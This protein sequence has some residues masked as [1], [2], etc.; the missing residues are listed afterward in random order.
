MQIV[1]YYNSTT[2][3]LK[4][5]LSTQPFSLRFFITEKQRGRQLDTKVCSSESVRLFLLCS[6]HISVLVNC[7]VTNQK[8][9]FTKG[10]KPGM[11][12][13]W[14]FIRFQQCL[15]NYYMLGTTTKLS[16]LFQVLG[17]WLHLKAR[18]ILLRLG[19]N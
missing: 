7:Q 18:Y 9:G 13:G 17:L 16:T 11:E 4:A 19:S 15:H 5:Y 8:T 2:N 12:S 1:A 14:P 3:T 6:V 10:L